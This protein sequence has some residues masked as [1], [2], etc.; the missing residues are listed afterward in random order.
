MLPDPTIPTLS[1]EQAQISGLTMGEGTSFSLVEFNPWD[2]SDVVASDVALGARPG[3]VSGFNVQKTRA[4]SFRVFIAGSPD[5][6]AATQELGRQLRQAMAP[7]SQDIALHFR[8]GGEQYFLV[9]RPRAVKADMKRWGA[10]HLTFEC[11]FL[12]TDPR[13]YSASLQE[14]SST[15]FSIAS[16][17]FLLSDQFPTF[18]TVTITNATPAVVSYTG[19]GQASGTPVYF[20]TDGTLPTGITANKQYYVQV[21]NANSFQLNNFQDNAIAGS[22]T[23]K[24]ATSS[25]GSGVHT[26]TFDPAGGW[27][28]FHPTGTSD[29][30]TIT[31]ASPAV[32]TDVAHGQTSGN[33]VYFTTD[34]TLPAGIT[35]N[36]QYYVQ[37]VTADTYKLNYLQ[38]NAISNLTAGLVVSTSAGSGTHTANYFPVGGYLDWGFSSSS[39]AVPVVAYN[40]GTVSTP[41]Q[42]A[43]TSTNPSANVNNI[44]ITHIE[45]QRKLVLSGIYLVAG[46]TLYLDSSDHA[47]LVYSGSNYV[48]RRNLLT[49]DSTWWDLK[50]GTNTF[51]V[52]VSGGG[53]ATIK[54]N[55]Y[56]I[57][58]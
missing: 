43:I 46:S 9:G 7:T 51:Q 25:A 28:N 20:T 42:A 58:V 31:N 24:V 4:V 50:V 40:S 37:V 44:S 18:S 21:V 22:G 55:W 38:D 35:A 33:P 39:P 23:G 14:S 10:G 8:I 6:K 32:V 15:A 49:A 36:Y 34:G 17:G 53:T 47:V 3:V 29:T 52:D 13:I 56:T 27:V 19:H 16:A 54:L 1:D 30:A 12:A 11:R 5:T 2:A 41:W 48:G 57:E 26:A 45:T